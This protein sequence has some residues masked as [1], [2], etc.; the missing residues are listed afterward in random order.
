MP[1]SGLSL[2]G[3]AP[4]F[5]ARLALGHTARKQFPRMGARQDAVVQV[6][7]EAELLVVEDRLALGVRQLLV[8]L[9]YPARGNFVG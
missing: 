8:G 4:V 5:A 3:N 6:L 7:H 2:G 9:T 1:W